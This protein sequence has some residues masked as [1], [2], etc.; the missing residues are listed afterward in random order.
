MFKR[1]RNEID[2]WLYENHLTTW[3]FLLNIEVWLYGRKIYFM[4]ILP[5]FIR[6]KCDQWRNGVIAFLKDPAGKNRF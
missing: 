4:R 6:A 5:I 1:V 3:K 2:E